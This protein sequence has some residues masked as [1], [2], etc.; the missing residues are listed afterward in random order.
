MYVPCTLLSPDTITHPVQ[1]D[2][3]WALGS[4]NLTDFNPA[5]H[6]LGNGACFM[7]SGKAFY[8]EIEKILQDPITHHLIKDP[9]LTPEGFTYG[10][11]ALTQRLNTSDI[12]GITVDSLKPNKKI[13]DILNVLHKRD[14]EI[15]QSIRDDSLEKFKSL[16]EDG[17]GKDIVNKA[18][19][20]ACEYGRLDMVSD[21][22]KN[23]ADVDV[24]IDSKTTALHAAIHNNHIHIVQALLQHGA[25]VDSRNEK[26]DTPLI[27]ACQ[28]G[29]YRMVHELVKGNADVNLAD[30]E[31]I[32]TLIHAMYSPVKEIFREIMTKNHFWM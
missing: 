20:L 7:P 3:V 4:H 1:C 2:C 30:K 19:I 29:N 22:L 8:T 14:E 32:P 24:V 10:R 11:E 17:L 13:E 25:N 15:L 21:L 28:E 16:L 26:G 27:R 31:G 9:V 6:S 23:K 5:Y 18:L 12:F